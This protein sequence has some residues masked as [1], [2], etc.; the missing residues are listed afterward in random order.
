MGSVGPRCSREPE[1]KLANRV[2]LQL[3]GKPKAP[4]SVPNRNGCPLPAAAK[5]DEGS[6]A[7][8]DA[9]T[10]RFEKGNRAAAGHVNPTARARADLQNALI[11]AV[12]KED[13]EALARRLLA[14]ALG[15]QVASA[16]L[17]LKYVVG[18]PAKAEDPDRVELEAWLLIQSWPWL[19]EF[20]VTVAR[21]FDP[22]A[23]AEFAALLIADTGE[24]VCKKL[25][26]AD[27]DVDEL[28]RPFV[29]KQADAIIKR[30]TTK[31]S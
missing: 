11:A 29:G 9:R 5:P 13:I 16:E 19:P 12:T 10:G 21:A 26:T 6:T 20:L 23:A 30:R 8:R 14:D 7:G 24:K 31:G 27:A 3:N 1:M 28:G 4:P 25:E 22:A 18:K 2:K 17:L 15:G